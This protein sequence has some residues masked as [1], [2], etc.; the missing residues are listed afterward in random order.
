MKRIG[1]FL[2]L[3]SLLISSGF[4]VVNPPTELYPQHNAQHVGTKTENG[5]NITL[6]AE[7][8]SGG[9]EY[10]GE[11]SVNSD[12]SGVTIQLVQ[13]QEPYWSVSLNSNQTYYWWL[14][15]YEEFTY[16]QSFPSS[17]HSFTTLND[18]TLSSP[19][20]SAVVGVNP[21]IQWAT[22][23]GASGYQIEYTVS[24]GSP[25]VVYVSGQSTG[26][27]TFSGLE[28][29]K[30]Y[31]WRVRARSPYSD[32]Q[33]GMTYSNWT[34]AR[35]F[36]TLATPVISS[37]S[38][39]NYL[40]VLPS[41]TWG[42][43]SGASSYTVQ[44][45]TNDTFSSGLQEFTG[46]TN[47]Y[48]TVVSA[49]S[50][51][52]TY[53]CRVIA[54]PSSGTGVATSST[55]SFYTLATPNITSQPSGFIGQNPT[56]TWGAVTGNN[57]YEIE[58]TRIGH[59]T[60]TTT[61]AINTTSKTVP[62]T[63]TEGYS[64]RIRA[65]SSIQ[66]AASGDVWSAWSTPKTYT[67]LPSP[68][69]NQPGSA[70][71]P[72]AFSA[73]WGAVANA[74][75]YKLQYAAN[76]AFTGATE[77]TTTS[78]TYAL[79]G[80]TP[81]STYYFR[82]GTRAAN[83][84]ASGIT[85]STTKSF[86]AI[87]T[88]TLSAPANT[89]TYISVTP[90]FSWTT[91]SGA[92][93]Y[94]IVIA[95][96]SG[97]TTGVITK[98]TATSPY[99]LSDVVL[100]SN[101]LYYWR[102]AAVIMDGETEIGI[103][104]Y[105]STRT[106]TTINSPTLSTPL[107]AAS[108]GARVPTFTWNAPDGS[109]NE[110]ELMF[111]ESSS[112]DA[113]GAFTAPIWSSIPTTVA[114]H[115]T[116]PGLNFGDN[117]TY[118]WQVRVKKSDGTVSRWSTAR[119]FTTMQAAVISSPANAATGVSTTPTIT[120]GAV[121]G[122]TGYS[123][124]YS[125]HS[126]ILTRLASSQEGVSFITGLTS[127]TATP[128]LLN[129]TTYYISV[130]SH[131]NG[132]SNWGAVVSFTTKIAT[133]TM[134][135]P[136][137]LAKTGTGFT[138]VVSSVS[139]A[140]AY[141]VERATNTAFTGATT[142][143]RNDPSNIPVTGLTSGTTYYWRTRAKTASGLYSDW[144]DYRTF[145]VVPTAQN[146][147]PADLTKDRS[148]SN[149]TVSWDAIDG[150]VSYTI[151]YAT[152]DAFTIGKQ[153]VSGLLTPTTTI[154]GLSYNTRYYWRVQTVTTY[155]NSAWSTPVS[156]W[157]IIAP[158]TLTTPT[159]AA[160]GIGLDPTL[161]WS[162][163]TNATSYTL[164]Y[165][166]TNTFTSPTT[167]ADITNTS[168]KISGL[169]HSQTYY[170]RVMAYVTDGD[171][172]KTTE[173]SSPF[174]FTTMA[175]LALTSPA[176]NA[177]KI[178]RSY[179]PLAWEAIPNALRYTVEIAE[180]TGFTVNKQT[181]ID[182]PSTTA[183][184]LL[185]HN[186]KYYWRVIGY[187]L[188][189]NSGWSE[190]RSFTTQ[191]TAP[192]LSTPSNYS[193]ARG[194]PTTVQWQIHSGAEKYRLQYA[195]D[196]G[197]TENVVTVTDLGTTSHTI[198]S[199]D[200]A[201]KYYWRVK[202]E[203]S[204]NESEW[205][206]IWDFTTMQSPNITFPVSASVTGYNPRL[207]WVSAGSVAH[208]LEYSKNSDFSGKLTTSLSG[209]QQVITFPSTGTWYCRIVADNGSAGT[210]TSAV[211]T[212]VVT[213]EPTVALPTASAITGITPRFE[214]SATTGATGYVVTVTNGDGYLKTYTTTDTFAVSEVLAGG[215]THSWTV[216]A[217]FGENMGVSVSLAR[218][219][220]TL[221]APIL[222]SP[223]NDARAIPE[224][225]TLTW[226][227]IDGISEY[228]VE[229]SKSDDFVP[230]TSKTVS[231]T[232][233]QIEVGSNQSY[234]YWRVRGINTTGGTPF[235]SVFSFL[236][237]PT[238][239]NATPTD[240][241]KNIALTPTLTWNTSDAS[242]Y[243]IEIG[244]SETLT[245][246]SSYTG[247]TTNSFSGVTGLSNNT[248]YYWRVR[249][250][251]SYGNSAWSAI[252][253]FTTSLAAPTLASPEND[254]YKITR[255]PTL[256]WGVVSGAI[257]Y[258]LQYATNEAFTSPN[259]ITM[260]TENT[261]T[262]TTSLSYATK[263]YWR[264]KA[265]NADGESIW[266]N[267]RSFTTE[268]APPTL[269]S[270]VNNATG[271]GVT[272]T[273]SWS[274]SVS[275]AEYDVMYAKDSDF[276]VSVTTV[277]ST[278]TS[279]ELSLHPYTQYWWKVRV[280]TG[281]NESQYSTVRT[282]TTLATP[283]AATPMNNTTATATTL[284]LM[285]NAV[286]GATSYEIK[287]GTASDLAGASVYTTSNAWYNVAG[288]TNFTSYYWSVRAKN[289]NNEY[290]EWSSIAQFRTKLATPTIASPVHNA[291]GVLSQG[292]SLT[293][294]SVNGATYYTVQYSQD[295]NFVNNTYGAVYENITATTKELPNLVREMYYF[296]RIKAHV[297]GESS[298]WSL[299]NMFKVQLSQPSQISPANNATNVP[300]ATTLSWVTISD[301][302]AYNVQYTKEADFDSGN[303]IS[304]NAISGTSTSVNLDYAS[305][306][307]WRI[308]AYRTG[309]SSGWNPPT[310]F[311][312]VPAPPSAITLSTPANGATGLPVT[313]TL[314]W[315]AASGATSYE[316]QYATNDQFTI[317]LVTESLTT[318]SKEVTGLNNNATY[319]WRVRAS[320]AG[321]NGDW[322]E[323]RSFTTII[324]LPAQVVLTTPSNNAVNISLAPT[325]T[326]E[327]AARA[328]TYEIEV[329]SAESYKQVTNITETTTS[330]TGLINNETYSW[331][332]RANNVA[333]NGAWSDWRT[334]TTIIQSPDQVTLI[335]PAN[336]ATNVE[337]TP[338]LT[339][340]V[341][342]RAGTYEV[343]IATND[344]FTTNLQQFTGITETSKPLTGLTNNTTY[345]W[346]VRA[347]NVGGNGAWSTVR[348][349]TTIV[350]NPSQVTLLTP[351]DA[352]TNVSITASLSW[353][354]LAGATSYEL[355]V[356]TNA[357]FT[358]GLQQFAGITETSK[359][360]STLAYGTTYYWRVRAANVGGNGDWSATRS[361]T[362]TAGIPGVVV[363]LSPTSGAINQNTTI[364]LS[365]NAVSG[366]TSYTLN[367]SKN[368]SF[369][370]T[371]SVTNIT[372]TSKEITGLDTASTYYWRVQA[373]NDQGSGSFSAV[374]SFATIANA[375]NTP[376]LVS[377][378]NN[379]QGVSPLP[380]LTWS[381][382]D[383]ATSYLFILSDRE[384]F[385]SEII[386]SIETGTSHVVEAPL[387]ENTKYYWKVQARD[388]HGQ[389]SSW[390]T[391]FNFTTSIQIAAPT[392]SSPT[393]NAT[394]QPL[395][396]NLTWQSVANATGYTIEVAKNS[397]FTS[398]LTSVT[399]TE[400]N[401]EIASLD[402]NTTYYWRV[403]GTNG[404]NNGTWSAVWSFTT[405]ALPPNTPSLVS[406]THESNNV[407]IAPTFTWNA[408]S[409]VD[410]YTL[411]VAEDEAF[412]LIITT[413]NNITGTNTSIT[414]LDYNT[415]Y[416]WRVRAYSTISG[417]SAWS[418]VWMFATVPMTP[419]TPTATSPANNATNIAVNPTLSWS[420]VTT[421]TKY[422]VQYATTLNFAVPTMIEDITTNSVDLSGLNSSTTYYWRVRAQN[423]GGNSDWSSTMS[424][425][426]ITIVPTT[427]I[428]ATPANNATGVTLTPTLTWNSVAH[429]TSY[430]LQVSEVDDFTTT[431]TSENNITDTTY[432]ITSL[433]N[434]TTY[435]W[436][437]RASNVAGTSEWSATFSF[438]TL[439]GVP[440]TPVLTYPTNEATAISRVVTLTWNTAQ[441]A[442]SYT[443]QVARHSSFMTN[444]VENTSV[445][446]NAFTT[447]EL[448]ANT[449]Y[450]W[451]VK[452]VNASAESEWSE[453]WSFR[454]IATA[455]A[456]VI[457]NG[458]IKGHG[459]V[460][461]KVAGETV[462]AT[463]L[464]LK[465]NAETTLY[466]LT[467]TAGINEFVSAEEFNVR[468]FATGDHTVALLLNNVT[469]A[470]TQF[471]TAVLLNNN[472]I[473]FNGLKL[474]GHGSGEQVLLL[475]ADVTLSNMQLIGKPFEIHFENKSA[476]MSIDNYLGNKG[477]LLRLNNS[478]WEVVG[479]SKK[480]LYIKESGIYA[481]AKDSNNVMIPKV[482]RSSLSQNYPNP[483]NPQTSIDV[484]VETTGHVT[485]TIFN[486]R[487]RKV[488]ELYNG[489]MTA[490]ITTVQWDGKDMHSKDMP[491]GV[492]Y[493]VVTI[494][495]QKFTRKMVMLK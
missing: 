451:R 207:T 35:Q 395:T 266:S 385:S 115:T 240:N 477:V 129:N 346:R 32:F 180:D 337:I 212:L 194:I 34:S 142:I 469:I 320:N 175:P 63:A 488:V 52:T 356:A 198:T 450:Y 275:G 26:S 410:S 42:A 77:H 91:V 444:I 113:T 291:I 247:I 458:I 294:N 453:V 185:A 468:K 70:I 191:M 224:T 7:Y 193:I 110:F 371:E 210:V 245:S 36:T 123:L 323:T 55:V 272:T 332:V 171:G 201:T 204:V 160:T 408:V 298:E 30:S 315:L 479:H 21:T 329:T 336:T 310:T 492:Y 102:V 125:I 39:G 389:V 456:Q 273:V 433:Q 429:A 265:V 279:I 313:T 304:L 44:I 281:E 402:Y 196:M 342:S 225:A 243:E 284:N 4:A 457:P 206:A 139:G 108:I 49:L 308:E 19:A 85:W 485:L 382:A 347:V 379:A 391:T 178:A 213:A 466:N 290:S 387:A 43:V 263:Y 293:W 343:D 345:Y 257:S 250:N 452:S 90:E 392:L 136:P 242:S 464:K 269:T 258:T 222:A 5:S 493:A 339:W 51:N 278:E 234:T 435:Y 117:S 254:A 354:E 209:T 72:V 100:E 9:I 143:E 338:T 75:S 256:S 95:K 438:T 372:T 454:T 236:N 484:S 155:G 449:V 312:T 324:A 443:I 473:M 65:K 309:D 248:K 299:I 461:A 45:A 25:V 11:W 474:A 283:Y 367:Y 229:W 216:T 374:W 82:V 358:V 58:Y 288:L 411:E 218:E 300:I 217:L 289:A 170:W 280:R 394:S 355:N 12:M 327:A 446:A 361:F 106:F 482:Q 430:E 351:T 230:S 366:A 259:E 15:S 316:L 331:R 244:T 182:T 341:A 122:A 253:S 29:N 168:Y 319:Y 419:D 373:V 465:V 64:V 353:N 47:T 418:T 364:T 223:L 227:A 252:T 79:S 2:F 59:E 60:S 478:N 274:S 388:S 214:W 383:R 158:T 463:D 460:Y 417:N 292:T 86:V 303:V 13:R 381:A 334:F 241:A 93:K 436:R 137:D 124:A 202:A 311:T 200:H 368:S 219:F 282:F 376:V 401:K 233:T 422:N 97:F 362:T 476:H 251:S 84:D 62:L 432:G 434:N 287:F 267:S 414:G 307:R 56:I 76:D 314:S 105:S 118:Y 475:A 378:S 16:A 393:N 33:N 187:S 203:T 89:A 157:T 413:K 48:Y 179:A 232:T 71:M 128:T 119:Q 306:Y 147:S 495:G 98:E 246:A 486:A 295:Q 99:T 130:R 173:W 349:F 61:S 296:W 27:Y 326:W 301:A 57:G 325:F 177:Y 231:A 420:V 166:A 135:T 69:I 220:T 261:R 215:K 211:S 277:Q 317:G 426:T 423:A 421:A 424:F 183:G 221:A 321:G 398:G 262:I 260:I 471:S 53:Y 112:V 190:T 404:V 237:Y 23:T 397:A 134:T 111:S 127:P 188:Y 264:V 1:V 416:Y 235:S 455:T 41:I 205:S 73:T 192:L 363:L 83:D 208:T 169:S 138:F 154:S 412:T 386:N 352:A 344:V 407:S 172:N 238:F 369:D 467:A 480:T 22:V 96:D 286:T 6:W 348:S 472:A 255:T 66:N 92:S 3:I 431:I 370:T 8:V 297:D 151:E 20:N 228:F 164:Q 146:Q 405:M 441:N 403:R 165:D 94:R 133:P 439:L 67:L 107:N 271:I 462:A 50:A 494:N 181:V 186:T 114:S 400:T 156:F 150:A 54:V 104:T 31:S 384:N 46:V 487:G 10:G 437:V 409:G 78:A 14:W 116:A 103:S 153:T 174:S 350:A 399:S 359:A 176:D 285:W 427:P 81:G 24:G 491:S 440:V 481:Y 328:S 132:D 390:S 428:L 189:G 490:G 365:W 268:L 276:S 445:T 161:S 149:A 109:N 163:V 470:T 195:T 318:T 87:T 197:I 88:P 131:G 330:V 442:S 357:A 322:S 167:I 18:T 340:N 120:W 28:A 145:Y 459:K 239:V 148:T 406:P 425:T 121:T 80:F 126:D 380:T 162:G 333:G 305:T 40:G 141:Q 375:P 226:G 37:P 74:T 68:T 270:P 159:N 199:L 415:I 448:L 17:I 360:M 144:S 140:L 249:G 483:F 152:N 101:T 377:P 335:A 38:A 489:T 302:T 396:T 447:T 184:F